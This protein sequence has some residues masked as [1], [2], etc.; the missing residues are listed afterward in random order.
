MLTESDSNC[1]LSTLRQKPGNEQVISDYGNALAWSA[2]A[3]ELVCNL[4]S[5]LSLRQRAKDLAE[6]SLQSDLNSSE[7]QTRYAF[8]ISGIA[9][10]QVQLG[11]LELARRDFEQVISMFERLSA[12][13]SSNVFFGQ[14]LLYSRA[15]LARLAG[16]TGG[17]DATRLVFRTL[18][19][20]FLSGSELA[21]QDENF[22][23]KYIDFLLGYAD[24]EY[25]LGNQGSAGKYL[26]S[27]QDLLFNSSEEQFMD[28]FDQE[29]LLQLKYQLWEMSG[30][31]D[32]SQVP[33]IPEMQRSSDGGYRSCTQVDLF[34]RMFLIEGD[35]DDAAR[36]V[37]YLRS[38]GYSDPAFMRFCKAQGL[39]R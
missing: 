1:V 25:R 9:K 5:A 39:C 2:D 3:Q 33:T 17:L 32:F 16:E 28:G 14:E 7:L 23:R 30:K 8:A 31:A 6:S 4:D 37:A 34:A 19:S 15:S 10:L 29:R 18:E 11:N 20:E 35:K 27:A 38:K 26:Q 22:Q 21:D 24:V 13:D 36:D 12:T